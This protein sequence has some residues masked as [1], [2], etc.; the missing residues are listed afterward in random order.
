M[1]YDRCRGDRVEG[2]GTDEKN[3]APSKSINILFSCKYG[4]KAGQSCN[5]PLCHKTA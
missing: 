2:N 5:N 3:Q 1:K 4:R